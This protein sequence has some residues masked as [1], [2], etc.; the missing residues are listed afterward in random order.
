ML[1]TYVTIAA[2]CLA[3]VL[4]LWGCATTPKGPTD[5]ELIRSALNQFKAGMEA[6]D[7]DRI[8]TFFSENFAGGEMGDKPRLA[9][10]IKGYME[11]GELK[12]AKVNIDEAVLSK[13]DASS[14][15]V[16]GVRLQ[17]NF[18]NGRLGFVM[19]KEPDGVWRATRAAFQEY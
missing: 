15:T 17:A 9:S 6:G 11:G 2:V 7:V 12:N 3:A 5:E 18:G 14:Y 4:A 13:T 16:E 8:M 1:R 19:T 10:A